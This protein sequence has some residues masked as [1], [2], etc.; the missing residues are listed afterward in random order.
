MIATALLAGGRSVCAWQIE[1]VYF[2]GVRR[3]PEAAGGGV[4]FVVRE[5]RYFGTR[6]KEGPDGATRPPSPP[7]SCLPRRTKFCLNGSID[8]ISSLI[9]SPLVVVHSSFFLLCCMDIACLLPKALH[10][11]RRSLLTRSSHSRGPRRGQW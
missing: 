6:G 10:S 5:D 7:S 4:F 1:V 3:R 2:K 8:A 11:W 9:L